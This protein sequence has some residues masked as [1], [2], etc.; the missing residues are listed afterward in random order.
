MSEAIRNVALFLWAFCA[1]N[2]E[3]YAVEPSTIIYGASETPSGEQDSAIVYMPSGVGNI[4]GQPI[5]DEGFES[6]ADDNDTPQVSSTNV[7]SGNGMNSAE[8][9]ETLP[10]NPPIS[11]VETPQKVNQQMQNTLYES[12]GRIYD[13]QSY[14]TEDISK[15]EKPNIQSTIATYPSY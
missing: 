3:T 9:S 1:V 8:I 11:S 14:P 12:G 5:D 13:V 2:S 7:V 10:Q 6:A 4:M 15:I